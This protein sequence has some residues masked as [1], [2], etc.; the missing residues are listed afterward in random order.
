VCFE[1]VRLRDWKYCDLHSFS[2]SQQEKESHFSSLSLKVLIAFNT[3]QSVQ[4]RNR[5]FCFILWRL[6]SKISAC[7]RGFSYLFSIPPNDDDHHISVMKLGHLL[8]RSGLMYPEISSNV[9]HDSFCQLE[10]SVS[11]PW[12]IPPDETTLKLA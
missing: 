12:V 1:F 2:Q 3:M 11:L 8:T 7:T 10:K 6:W 9:C 5:N 4:M